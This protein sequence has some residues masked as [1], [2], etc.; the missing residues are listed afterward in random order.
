MKRNLQMIF[1]D[2]RWNKS[3]ETTEK[4]LRGRNLPTE[5]QE[6]FR[7]QHFFCIWTLTCVLLCGRKGARIVKSSHFLKMFNLGRKISLVCV[8]VGNPRYC[9]ATVHVEGVLELPSVQEVLTTFH[10]VSYYIKRVTTSWTYSITITIIF[11]LLMYPLGL[12]IRFFSCSLYWPK[13]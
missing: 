7:S 8:A 12:R 4:R 3:S 5:Q 9:P 13:C 11:S 6:K 2:H 1:T 10:K